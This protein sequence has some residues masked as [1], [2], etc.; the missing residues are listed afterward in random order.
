MRGAGEARKP[1]KRV[2]RGRARGSAAWRVRASCAAAGAEG[3]E[4]AEGG[5][6][7][8]AAHIRFEAIVGER[9]EELGLD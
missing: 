1:G 2:F 8:G 9:G 3:A 4:A 6:E 5:K 7:G